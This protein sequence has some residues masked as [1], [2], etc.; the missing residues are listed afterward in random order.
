MFTHAR[1]RLGLVMIKLLGFTQ[2]ELYVKV[3]L[4]FTDWQTDSYRK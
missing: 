1:L 3:F 2:K 4:G